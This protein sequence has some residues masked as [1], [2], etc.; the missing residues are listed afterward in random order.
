M[1]TETI[2]SILRGFCLAIDKM[3]D[4]TKLACNQKSKNLKID[5]AVYLHGAYRICTHDQYQALLLDAQTKTRDDA[6]MRNIS[7]ATDYI[8]KDDNFQKINFYWA[9]V[10]NHSNFLYPTAPLNAKKLVPV[11]KKVIKMR[12]TNQPANIK[13]FFLCLAWMLWMRR[14]IFCIR[15]IDS[16]NGYYQCWSEAHYSTN[17]PESLQENI[18]QL[19]QALSYDLEKIGVTVE[20]INQIAQEVIKDISGYNALIFRPILARK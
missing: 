6:S 2:P 4:K 1:V 16:H 14:A 5:Q 15:A 11:I 10:E 18:S 17:F 13:L 9:E 7:A 12:I 20:A 19:L 8:V 3:M